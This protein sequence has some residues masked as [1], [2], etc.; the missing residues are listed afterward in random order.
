MSPRRRQQ[1]PSPVRGNTLNRL[2]DLLQLSRGR[3]DNF[4]LQ[5]FDGTGDVELYLQQFHENKEANGW[6]D[7]GVLLHLKCTLG[8][9]ATNC[10][11][12]STLELFC[13]AL[14]SRFSMSTRCA[15]EKLHQLRYEL[16]SS[17]LVLGSEVERLVSIGYPDADSQ[18]RNTIALDAFMRALNHN[19]L[20]VSFSRCFKSST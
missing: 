14:Q 16:N 19:V 9:A 12:G 11:R 3:R 5:K 18:S 10:G 20:N 15:C 17:L 2:V 6:T 4:R 13:Q 8:G 7:A 1:T